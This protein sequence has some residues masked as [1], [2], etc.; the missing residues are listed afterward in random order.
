MDDELATLVEHLGR[1]STLPPG[2]LR[3][4]AQDVLAFYSETVSEYVMRRHGELMRAGLKNE[5]IFARLADE[6]TTRSFAAA[7]L[8]TRQIRRMVYG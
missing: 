2:Q 6:V 7:P 1:T 5:A 8:S 4:L 3:R